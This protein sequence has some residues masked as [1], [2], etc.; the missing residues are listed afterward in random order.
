MNVMT[1]V[2]RSPDL[3]AGVPAPQGRRT[4][5]V[6]ARGHGRSGG[7]AM[8]LGWYGDAD[9]AAAVSYLQRRSDVDGRRIA[10]VG[11]STGGEEA[12][13]AAA[14][15]PRIRAVVAEGATNRVAADK[16]FLPKV[17]G[18]RGSVQQRVDAITFGLADLLTDARPPRPLRDAVR[19]TSPRP[20]LLATNPA[21]WE[22]RITA[23]L[24]EAVG[25]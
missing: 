8:D 1:A 4:A 24:T 17:H 5:L 10:A 7:R 3:A 6:D 9:V 19:A 16:A 11:M 20:I 25:S 15:E 23:F 13:G 22:R 18:W 14:T 2:T 12:I 21:G